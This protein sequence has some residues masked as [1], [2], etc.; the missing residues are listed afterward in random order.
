MDVKSLAVSPSDYPLP[1][2]KRDE[3][4]LDDRSV[5]TRSM[6]GGQ[7]GIHTK[8][9]PLFASKQQPAECRLQRAGDFTHLVFPRHLDYSSYLMGWRPTA[10][11]RFG[12]AVRRTE[13]KGGRS[14]GFGEPR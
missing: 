9:H 8:G 3:D 11:C 4:R 2:G 10:A 6:L 7:F 5:R 14:F 1:P 13:Y 12:N